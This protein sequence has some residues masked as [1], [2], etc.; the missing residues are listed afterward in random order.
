MER[1]IVITGV[2]LDYMLVEMKK[3]IQEKTGFPVVKDVCW[4]IESLFDDQQRT[5]ELFYDFNNFTFL[6]SFRSEFWEEENEEKEQL[7]ETIVTTV[8]T[9]LKENNHS[10]FFKSDSPYDFQ[11]HHLTEDVENG[12]YDFPFVAIGH[13]AKTLLH[14]LEEMER[15]IKTGMYESNIYL[16]DT[17]FKGIEIELVPNF[18]G[19]PSWIAV[20]RESRGFRHNEADRKHEE[21][22]NTL[23][24]FESYDDFQTFHQ[25]FQEKKEEQNKLAKRMKEYVEEKGATFKI[26]YGYRVNFNH[27]RQYTMSVELKP[28]GHF[29]FESMKN[30]RLFG[31][32]DDIFEY[33]VE[34]MDIITAFEHE[35]HE[36]MQ[37][38]KKSCPMAFILPSVNDVRVVNRFRT[39]TGEEVED[40]SFEMKM[41]HDQ[42]ETITEVGYVWKYGEKKMFFEQH[43]DMFAHAFSV[44]KKE[45]RTAKIKAL[46]D[47]NIIEYLPRFLA[48]VEGQQFHY[49]EEHVT[50]EEIKHELKK[51]YENEH[52]EITKEMDVI[53]MGHLKVSRIMENQGD[54]IFEKA[55]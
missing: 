8:M 45:E 18:K 40:M 35:M 34:E 20:K 19:V 32:V 6:V 2:Q 23:A 21:I 26:D 41:M 10:C 24:V 12:F 15:D 9:Y 55:V 48:D 38:M 44:L 30:H 54:F 14:L 29:D 1:W 4:D 49:D 53:L 50:K 25:R 27:S 42:F 22:E 7:A 51:F 39:Y 16:K 28:T 36:F 13:Q 37:N 5:V 46:Y 43:E 17:Y 52:P 11:E 3:K 47:P 33:F 31:S